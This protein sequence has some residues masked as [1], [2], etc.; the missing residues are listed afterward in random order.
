MIRVDVVLD[1]FAILDSFVSTMKIYI[2]T[3]VTI[4]SKTIYP[5]INIVY[6]YISPENSFAS[7]IKNIN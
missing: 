2:Q 3:L 5:S 7:Q 4:N 6:L 1:I